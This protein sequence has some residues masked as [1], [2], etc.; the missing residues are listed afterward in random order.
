MSTSCLINSLIPEVKING[1]TLS[2][3]GNEGLIFR[4][5]TGTYSL[6]TPELSTTKISIETS[7]QERITQS[8]MSWYR[9]N[10]I[11]NFLRYRVLVCLG[12]RNPSNLDFITQRFNEYHE[13]SGSF[14]DAAGQPI[15][16]DPQ[17]YFTTSV[18]RKLGQTRTNLNGQQYTLPSGFALV[19]TAQ[20]QA[21]NYGFIYRPYQTSDPERR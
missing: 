21:A 5:E 16:M 7:I 17:R 14:V 12:D 18:F 4:P 13:L 1:V 20:E 11:L 6:E 8:N 19:N 3:V 15:T 2:T 9:Q 10:N